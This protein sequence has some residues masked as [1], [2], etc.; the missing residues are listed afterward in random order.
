[1]ISFLRDGRYKRFFEVK[2]FSDKEME[3]ISLARY[4]TAGSILKALLNRKAVPHG[5]LAFQLSITSQGLTWQMNRLKASGIVR[6]RRDGMKV[7]YSIEEAH[8][9]VLAETMRMLGQY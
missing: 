4:V 5:D 2:R 6:E 7:I 8:I 1:M 3:M 9:S